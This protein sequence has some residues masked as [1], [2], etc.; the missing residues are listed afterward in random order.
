MK[1]EEIGNEI[2]KLA[3]GLDKLNEAEKNSQE[4]QK[5]MAIFQN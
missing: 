2:E 1:R 4:L 3:G 5:N